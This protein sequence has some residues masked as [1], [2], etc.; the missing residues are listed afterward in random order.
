M[1]L[2]SWSFGARRHL[3]RAGPGG[4]HP[5][6]AGEVPAGAGHRLLLHSPAEAHDHRGEGLPP[7]SA[8]LPPQ[9]APAGG[10]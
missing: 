7:G 8:L 1:T 10:H 9:P 6:G 4:G 2:T 3:Q 5:P